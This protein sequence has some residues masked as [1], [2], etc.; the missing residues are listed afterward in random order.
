MS[1]GRNKGERKKDFLNLTTHSTHFIYVYMVSNIWYSELFNPLSLL[2][3]LV[4]LSNG[5]GS[6]ICTIPDRI[7]HTTVFVTPVMDNWLE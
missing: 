7:V 2:H 4:F 1:R 6:F 3:M 5:K